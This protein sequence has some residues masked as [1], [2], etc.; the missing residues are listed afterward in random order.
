MNSYFMHSFALFIWHL[1]PSTDTTVYTDF[2]S[3]NSCCE[4]VGSDSVLLFYCLK[5]AIRYWIFLFISFDLSF[6]NNKNTQYENEREF[7]AERKR[8]FVCVCDHD[9]VLC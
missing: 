4:Y 2:F 3:L 6:V 8:V 1:V 9:L 5:K 7:K